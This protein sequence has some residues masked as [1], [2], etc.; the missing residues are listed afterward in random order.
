LEH[1]ENEQAQR[2]L[3][4]EALKNIQINDE[5]EAA[6]V[7]V[8][9]AE[10]TGQG[11]TCSCLKRAGILVRGVAAFCAD[12][13]TGA[14]MIANVRTVNATILPMLAAPFVTVSDATR[15]DGPPAKSC[16]NKTDNLLT[17]R[18]PCRGVPSTAA[19][20]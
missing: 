6:G 15:A 12:A 1:D 8:P 17:T 3:A 18:D 5:Q 20:L 11:R 2:G 10:I 7:A 13:I 19:S 16:L 9:A 4:V 14:L